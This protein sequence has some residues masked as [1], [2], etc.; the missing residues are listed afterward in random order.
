VPGKPW[1]LAI[2]LGTGGPKTGAVSL[3]GDLLGHALGSVTT[4]YTPDGGAVQDTAEWW[5]RIRD[6]VR[7]LM[8]SKVAAPADLAGVGITGQ[9]GS[10]IPV[11]AA[12]G[13]VGDCRLWSD[14]RGGPFSAKAMGGPISLF[15]YS[16]VNMMRWI[17]ITGGAPSPNGADPLGHELYLRNCEPEIYARADA[18]LEP[19]DYVG[20]R[21][22]GLRAATP[23]SMILSWLTDNRPGAPVAY[24][25][26][27]VAR[28]G[29]DP[30]RLPELVPTGSVL[31][32]ILPQVA[33]DLGVPAG[34]PVVAG[35]PDL[36]TAFIGSG[37]VAP[38]EAHIT[39]SSSSWIG[40][41]VPFKR[42]DVIHQ[43][44]SVPGLRPGAYLVANN[45]ETAGLCLQWLRDSIFGPDNGPA[46]SWTPAYDDLIKVAAKA[47]AGAG[48]VI[49]TPWLKG[50]RTPVDD[51]TLRGAF[52]NLSLTT[53]RARI[54]R[55]VLEGVAFNARWLLDAVEGFAKRPMPTLR[56][57]G[58]GASSDLWCQIH[59]DI[60]GRRIERVAEPM[61]TN[62]RGAALFAAMSLGKISLDEVRSLVRV[63]AS[64]EPDPDAVT[65]Y[66]PMY[67][68]FKRLY[69]RLHGVYARLNASKD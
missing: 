52:L 65:T 15:G 34:V 39:I 29:R 24:V 40:C 17:Q 44:A 46:E 64:F 23:A 19:V 10:T 7:S 48:G 56:I 22:T 3:H 63:T 62:L 31:G 41:E 14:T 69:G 49:F 42:T 16:P 37:A 38:F 67:A 57:L 58:G 20:L 54:V 53:D 68:E 2:D 51:R 12:G 45:H 47:P 27:L 13:A 21:F 11:D 35:M 30:A 18:L 26:A 8:A 32:G 61:Y 9:W 5:S 28:S 43:I 36:H 55:A 50:E 25:P 59:A 33:E 6:G 60:L 4:R 1:F 66:R